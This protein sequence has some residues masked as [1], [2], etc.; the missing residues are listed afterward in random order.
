MISTSHT[1]QS[2]SKAASCEKFLKS[3]IQFEATSRCTSD[4]KFS[5]PEKKIGKLKMIPTKKNFK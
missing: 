2:F 3:M 5:R 1:T 4:T